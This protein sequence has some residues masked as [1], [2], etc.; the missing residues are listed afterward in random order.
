M[1]RKRY[2]ELDSRRYQEIR[3]Y[4]QELNEKNNEIER[5]KIEHEKQLFRMSEEIKYLKAQLR[6]NENINFEELS[7][8]MAISTYMGEIRPS[9]ENSIDR[10]N[11]LNFTHIERLSK[12]PA[13]SQ[14]SNMQKSRANVTVLNDN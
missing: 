9:E 12:S 4:K 11:H 8:S 6:R 1:E 14:I 2:E 7:K 13:H 3:S 10:S 5:L